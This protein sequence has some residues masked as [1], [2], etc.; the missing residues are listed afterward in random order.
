MVP[1]ISIIGSDK[2]AKTDTV[3]ALV[4]E[5]SARGVKVGVLKHHVHDNFEID[6]PGKASYRHRAAG[7][8]EV[9][10][11][12]P[13]MFAYIKDNDCEMDLAEVE[14]YFSSG[15]DIIIAEGYA[16]SDAPKIEAPITDIP[17]AVD[18]IIAEF[19]P[20]GMSG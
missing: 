4:K 7:A 6:I 8:C 11:S 14:K 15:I 2:N 20:P 10:V 9:A 1:M 19:L 12:S 17:A 5:L 18:G 3:E 16:S 13:T